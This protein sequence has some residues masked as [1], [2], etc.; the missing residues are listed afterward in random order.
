MWNEARQ[1]VQNPV[2][3]YHQA[4][5]CF[6]ASLFGR[7][8]HAFLEE[9][10][11]R[12]DKKEVLFLCIGSDRSTGDS[13]GPLVGYKLEKGRAGAYPLIGTLHQSVHATNLEETID[14]IRLEYPDHVV[15][16]IDASIGRKEHVGYITMGI[17]SLKPGLGVRKNLGAVGDIYITGIVGSGSNLEP[18]LL[19]NTRLS[20]VMELADCIY[21]GICA[22]GM[23]GKR[24]GGER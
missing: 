21:E 18:L 16:A 24:K 9:M 1:L 23:I 7:Q 8:L 22:C 6:S 19:Q 4:G 10:K 3:Y 11:E 20:V 15:V 12:K 14:R 17:G 2:T 5:T 13:L